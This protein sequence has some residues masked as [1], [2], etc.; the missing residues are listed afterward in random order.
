MNVIIHTFYLKICCFAKKKKKKWLFR[1]PLHQ[2]SST[3]FNDPVCLTLLVSSKSDRQSI[4]T[5]E[6]TVHI[7]P[8]QELFIWVQ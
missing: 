4:Y 3:K 2:S 7:N 6:I 8:T 1:F 5:K